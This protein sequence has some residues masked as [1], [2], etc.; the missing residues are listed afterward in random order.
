[1]IEPAGDT[2]FYN[3][4]IYIAFIQTVNESA[5]T[6]GQ[7]ETLY[8]FLNRNIKEGNIHYKY[9]LYSYDDLLELNTT[10]AFNSDLRSWPKFTPK[11]KIYSMTEWYNFP[12]MYDFSG[13]PVNNAANI[14]FDYVVTNSCYTLV[15]FF[16]Q[17]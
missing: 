5:P 1:M 15:S 14:F 11:L 10:D 6:K 2:N 3:T 16:L 12:D 9:S 7:Y 8:R 4:S 13:S 17:I